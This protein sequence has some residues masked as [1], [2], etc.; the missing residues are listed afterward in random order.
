MFMVG[1]PALALVTVIAEEQRYQELKKICKA[2]NVK[3]P[4]RIIA[5]TKNEVTKSKNSTCMVLVFLAVLFGMAI[6]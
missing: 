4:V 2:L 5:S 6:G 1:A 3:Q